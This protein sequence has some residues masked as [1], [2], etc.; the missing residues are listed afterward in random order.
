TDLNGWI[1]P[2]AGHEVFTGYGS[3]SGG[4]LTPG[5]K[6]A[7]AQVGWLNASLDHF[8]VTLHFAPCDS[9]QLPLEWKTLEGGIP[10]LAGE[11]RLE[12]SYSSCLAATGELRLVNGPSFAPVFLIAGGEPIHL[13]LHGGTLVPTPD[14]L[15]GPYF[16]DHKG[17]H[18]WPFAWSSLDLPD[19]A[20]WLQAWVV[21]PSA[22]A[23]VSATDALEAVFAY[24]G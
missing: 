4:A 8:S 22:P 12:A 24:G 23:G 18:G 10:G 3:W 5:T 1:E 21:D 17:A 15:F 9:V 6:E 19:Q 7:P 16:L 20:F 14:L 2:F 13:P 11:P